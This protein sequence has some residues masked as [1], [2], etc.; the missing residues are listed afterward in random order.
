MVR[1]LF[2]GSLRFGNWS[3]GSLEFKDTPTTFLCILC[4]WEGMTRVR[5][6]LLAFAITIFITRASGM[7]V[8]FA[9]LNDQDIIRL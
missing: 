5:S 1:N 6:L 3:S 2:Q 4:A 9:G 7:T 8:D